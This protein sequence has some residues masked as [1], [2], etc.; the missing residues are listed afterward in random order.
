M[1]RRALITGATGFL[2]GALAR[3]LQAHGWR[4][5]ALGR[6]AVA[7]EVLRAAGMEFVQASL[8]DE[9]ATTAACEGADVVFHCGALSSPWG[10]DAAF[11]AA[12]VTGT[13]NVI[14]GCVRHGVARLV[15]VSTPSVYFDFRHRLNLTEESPLASRPVNAYARSKL[16]A[17]QC[18][19]AAVARGLDA[20]TLR[21]RAI[22]GPGDTT[23]FPRLLRVAQHEKFPLIG[24]GD[25]IMDVTF[26]GNAVDAL[27]AAGTAPG[28]AG[29]KYNITNGEPWARSALLGEL[30]TQTGQ[31]F[32]TRAVPLSRAMAAA[33]LME[34]ASR[35]FSASRWEPPLTRYSAAVLA[36][37]QTFDLSAARRDLGYSP[38]VGVGEGIRRFAQWWRAQP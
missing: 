12:N 23:L 17:E 22:F 33:R 3:K 28:I 9:A 19:D 36:F 6:R 24:E 35:I 20:V 18:V 29:R 37:S 15:N 27:A 34:W 21:P 38:A 13:R 16:I 32:T 14:A 25:P 11:V 31:E 1:S 30:F 5:R 26:V 4:V 8:E 2:G 10:R 7:G